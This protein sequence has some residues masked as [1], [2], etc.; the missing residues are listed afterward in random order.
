VAV[1]ETEDALVFRGRALPAAAGAV[2]LAG[3]V[4]VGAGFVVARVETY[5]AYL[6]ALAFVTIVALGALIL[7]MTT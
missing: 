7:Q 2:A 6:T 4:G 1:S 5:F 3:W